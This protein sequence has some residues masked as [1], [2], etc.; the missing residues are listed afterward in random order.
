MGNETRIT[1][2]KY[3]AQ[4]RESIFKV[5]KRVNS[6][7]LRSEVEEKE[8]KKITYIILSGEE[9]AKPVEKEPEE[10][11]TDYKAAY[12]TLKKEYDALKAKYDALEK[13]PS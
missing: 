6:G 5:L 13:E 8:G 3:A 2:E 9:P 7:E 1:V 12:E 4:N 10:T 11:I